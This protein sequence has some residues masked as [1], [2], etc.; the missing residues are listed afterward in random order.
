[1]DYKKATRTILATTFWVSFSEFFRNEILFK[2]YWTEHFQNL[3]ITFPSKPINGAVWGLWSL[4]FAIFIF[5]ISQKFT[6]KQTC[7]IVWFSGFLMM[8]VTIGNLG[9]L[10]IKLLTFAVPLSILESCL[11]A[12]ITYKLST[13]PKL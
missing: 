8:W 2:S 7:A 10:P 6:L 9:V 12:L 5:I 3:G 1:M 13:K 4:L 11:A